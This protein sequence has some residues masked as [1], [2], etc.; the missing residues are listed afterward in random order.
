MSDFMFR[1]VVGADT[2]LGGSKL[3]LMALTNDNRILQL[4]CSNIPVMPSSFEID[5]S[6]RI[7]YV[8]DELNENA[9]KL[10]VYSIAE[11]NKLLF[12]QSVETGGSN[13]CH[14]AI[15]RREKLLYVS[16]YSGGGVICYN[17][18]GN[19][20][21]DEKPLFVM[22]RDKSYHCVLPLREGFLAIDSINN[23]LTHATYSSELPDYT[24]TVEKI[25]SPRQARY[26]DEKRILIVSE[27]DS[28]IYIYNTET[29][30]I[31][32]AGNTCIEK[33]SNNKASSIWVSKNNRTAIVSNR[34]EDSLVVFDI[35]KGD[36]GTLTDPKALVIHGDR[37]PRDFDV[38]YDEEYAVV[39]YT[40]SNCVKIFR[41]N[42]NSKEFKFIA[43]QKVTAPIGIRI[44]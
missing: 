14:V 6:K 1:F 31:S 35:E 43:S 25:Q 8:T 41:I 27:N 29:E 28:V 11:E 23:E 12:L 37:C 42:I 26:C 33:A 17:L 30:R 4:D 16:H 38:S 3:R 22:G 34:G 2:D 9:G 40:K 20:L 24:T 5:Q 19:G 10:I 13:P 15:D 36:S 18:Q 32:I 44:L 21:I 7:L 39:G